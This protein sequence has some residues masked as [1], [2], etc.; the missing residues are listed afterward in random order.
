DSDAE[1]VPG[2]LEEPVNALKLFETR[3]HEKTSS[4]EI[5]D[6]ATSTL[7][8][9]RSLWKKAE[10]I[11][12]QSSGRKYQ[13]LQPHMQ[14]ES[15][16]TV[17]FCGSDLK[18][19]AA[20]FK[21]ISGQVRCIPVEDPRE[22][23]SYMM[24]SFCSG[25]RIFQQVSGLVQHLES[26][27]CPLGQKE[28]MEACRLQL[29]P[30]GASSANVRLVPSSSEDHDSQRDRIASSVNLQNKVD[31]GFSL[32]RK[33]LSELRMLQPAR[34]A[35]LAT[36]PAG[37]LNRT[38]QEMSIL[39]QAARKRPEAPEGAQT[40]R[41]RS[42]DLAAPMARRVLKG[43][44]RGFLE[45]LAGRLRSQGISISSPFTFEKYRSFCEVVSPSPTDV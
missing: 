17:V 11:A 23:L 26:G 41:L 14:V 32:R 36:E 34:Y 6:E 10:S 8:S 12:G 27:E 19:S 4:H 1:T 25:D 2:M 15:M 30:S 20:G 38:L 31:D 5:C 21:G 16:Q 43:P 9:R 28:L 13:R 42:K 3:L 24:C 18:G 40:K 35:E 7:L 44:Q 22:G 33:L 45:A 29:M 37:L 39:V